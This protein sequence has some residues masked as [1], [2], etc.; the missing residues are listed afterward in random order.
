MA[1]PRGRRATS[2]PTGETRRRFEVFR[3]L[4]PSAE[5]VQARSDRR[6]MLRWALRGHCPLCGAPGIR[7]GWNTVAERCP[8]CNLRF[9]RERGFRPLDAGDLAANDPGAPP[10]QPPADRALG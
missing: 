4:P 1:T 5:V 6:R 8:W 10:P 9:S 2:P 7:Q 3:P